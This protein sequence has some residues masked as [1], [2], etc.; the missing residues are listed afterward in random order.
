MQPFVYNALPARV[1]FG[2]G[3]LSQVGREIQTLRCGKALVLTGPSQFTKGEVLKKDL[4][5]LC[6]GLYSNATMHAP[7]KITDEAVELAQNLGADCV[8]AIGGGS[9]VGLAKAIALRTDLPQI[10]IP[11]SYSG[12]EVLHILVVFY[13]CLIVGRQQLS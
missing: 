9:A 3:T 12:S 13:H 10:V 11:T 8:V 6:V 5:D 1:I 4:G 2:S 7:S